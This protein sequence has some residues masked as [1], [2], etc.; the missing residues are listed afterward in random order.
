[1]SV[2]YKAIDWNRQKK[3]YDKV[4]WLGILFSLICAIGFQFL[5]HPNGTLETA[6]IRSLAIVAFI[7]LHIILVIGPLCRLD[8]RYLPLLYNRRHMG[9]SMFIIALAHG[10]FSM[11]QFHALGDVNPLISLFTSN[12]HYLSISR[13]PFQVLGFIALVILFVMAATSH[14]FWLKNLSPKIWKG[15]HML[16]YVAYALII[17]HVATGALQYEDHAIYWLLLLVGFFLVLALHIAA[18]FKENRELSKKHKLRED[19]FYEVCEINEIEESCGKPFF[20]EQVNLAIFKH[21]GKVYAVNNI[22]KHQMGPIGEG[23]IIDGCI[24][25]PWHGYQYLPHDGKSPPPFQ[26]QLDTY[27]VQVIGD[28]VWVNPKAQLIA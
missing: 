20:V 10:A 23:K 1:M 21:E 6:L 5:L 19:G 12:E 4:L 28:K 3:K 25:C 7:L 15:L 9:V 17:V 26:E 24:T 11:V 16:V 14:D 13:F 22:C 27:A 8:R 2:R 18:G